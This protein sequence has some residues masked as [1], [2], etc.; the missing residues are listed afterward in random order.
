M[1]DDIPDALKEA[2]RRV[3][4]GFSD[5]AGGLSSAPKISAESY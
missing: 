2:S 5:T 1:T 4:M 3:A